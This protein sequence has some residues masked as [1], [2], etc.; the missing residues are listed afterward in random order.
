MDTPKNLTRMAVS[1]TSYLT[2]L[3]LIGTVSVSTLFILRKDWPRY[4]LGKV[5]ANAVNASTVPDAS[6]GIMTVSF[7]DL[8]KNPG[9]FDSRTIRVNSTLGR[10]Q[11]Y[12]TFYDA[13]CV[14][15][16]PLVNVVFEPSLEF[17]RETDSS[18]KLLEIV[19][20]S[21]SAREGNVHL[22]VLAVGLFRAIPPGLR[23]DFTELQYEFK[24]AKIEATAPA[25]IVGSDNTALKNR[26]QESL[27]FRQIA[28]VDGRTHDG[29][30]FADY[31]FKASDCVTVS[32]KV[33][34]FDS[35]AR[36]LAAVQGEIAKASEIVDQGSAFDDL[37]R[38]VGQRAVLRFDTPSQT[39]G[40][41]VIVSNSG[42]QFHAISSSSL[43]HLLEF[44]KRSRDLPASQTL[45][46]TVPT[47]NLTF[48]TIK[49]RR[50]SPRT[51]LS[52]RI[53]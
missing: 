30:T 51:A 52:M 14:P 46:R 12:V 25:K 8:L 10:F 38:Q 41:S 21:P 3:L 45:A 22:P 23:K 32:D 50:V 37:G 18:Q 24:V 40:Y 7:C 13:N 39:E 29:F 27:T 1:K 26:S 48:E 4:V 17:D 53:A 19:S 36:A 16:H 43:R 20:G 42:S 35:A 6:P 33:V 5:Y 28:V 31:H 15:R 2:T 11:D 34:S 9:A 44:E 47:G 49:L